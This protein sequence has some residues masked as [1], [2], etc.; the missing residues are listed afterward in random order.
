[1]PH[2]SDWV[3]KTL[4]R[5]IGEKRGRH[6][7]VNEAYL[8][9]AKQ[10]AERVAFSTRAW[11]SLR[12][13]IRDKAQLLCDAFGTR[14]IDFLVGPSDGLAMIAVPPWATGRPTFMG[15]GHRLAVD[16]KPTEGIIAWDCRGQNGSFELL[17]DDGEVKILTSQ[18][19]IEPN[20]LA[21]SLL[22]LLLF[23]S[24]TGESSE[25]ADSQAIG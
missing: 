1:M 19:T 7:G 10:R 11:S 20:Q 17:V 18:G 2:D 21:E 3:E 14:V 8:E 9:Q 13:M 6:W 5:M 22:N 15:R 16:F 24:M 12:A 4:A 23:G 25:Q